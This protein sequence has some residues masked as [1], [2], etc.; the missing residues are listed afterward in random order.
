MSDRDFKQ[1]EHT[2]YRRKLNFLKMHRE[3]WL[4]KKFGVCDECGEVMSD[5]E[6]V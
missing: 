2:N 1:N 3:E 6:C 5:C 4:T